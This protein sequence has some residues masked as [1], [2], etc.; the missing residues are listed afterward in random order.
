MTH[1]GLKAPEAEIQGC[2]GGKWSNRDL[3]SRPWA[4]LAPVD[5]AGSDLRRADVSEF[6]SERRLPVG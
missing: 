2:G 3:L 5:D 6:Q 4:R 1:D